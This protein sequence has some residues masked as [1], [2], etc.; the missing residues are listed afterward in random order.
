MTKVKFISTQY[1]KENT[2]IEDNVDDDKIVPYIHKAQDI[3]IQQ[4][5]GS[6]FYTHIKNQ[7]INGTVTPVED[8]LLRDFIQ[9]AIG[10][11]AFYYSIPFLSN[12]IT[13]KGVNK[14][15]SQWSSNSD[16]NEVK[17]LQK[18]VRD[19]AEFYLERLI[20]YLCDNKALFP[21]YQNATDK[22]MSKINKSYF[23]GI[24]LGDSKGC[25]GC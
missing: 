24:Y 2:S 9:P 13:N 8:S 4:V 22:N 1:I 25:K 15:T 3:H 21:V 16:L 11:W 20:Q 23:S 5:L 12:K 18:S 17:Y 10:E 19:I 7:I 6:D 14:E